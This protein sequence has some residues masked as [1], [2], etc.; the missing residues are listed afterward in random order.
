MFVLIT[1]LSIRKYFL[2][3][4]LEKETEIKTAMSIKFFVVFIVVILTIS[5]AQSTNGKKKKAVADMTDSEI[6]RIY[7]EWEVKTIVFEFKRKILGESLIIKGK[8][9]GENTRR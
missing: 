5:G 4:S 1:S 3:Q 7:D 2:V 9:K 6:E 8:R